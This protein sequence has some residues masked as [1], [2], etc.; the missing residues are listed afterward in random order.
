[1]RDQTQRWADSFERELTGILALQSDIARGLA[2]SLAL[3]LLPTEQQRLYNAFLHAFNGTD[4]LFE[5]RWNDAIG[6][7]RTALKMSPGLPLAAN[8][9]IAALHMKGSYAEALDA[10]KTYAG[11]MGYVEVEEILQ[12][13]G[14]SEEYRQTMRQAADALAARSRHTFVSRYDIVMFYT[15]AEERD[16]AFEWIENGIKARDPN[17][18][19]LG[20]PDFELLHGDP[21]FRAVMRRLN[22]PR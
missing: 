19:Y 14:A 15:Y 11:I 4:L 1:M 18:P 22:L 8:P 20:E 7:L 5:R 3:T 12:R 16:R 17:L 21:R 13:S 6:E 2:A 9:L 10:L